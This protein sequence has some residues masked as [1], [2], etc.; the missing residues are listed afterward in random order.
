MDPA[1]GVLLPT[2]F[3]NRF[4]L[5]FRAPVL[6]GL[7]WILWGFDVY[8]FHRFNIP[9]VELLG[10]DASTTLSPWKIVVSGLVYITLIAFVVL[11]F[12]YEVPFHDVLLF[13]SLLYLTLSFALVTPANVMH[14]AGRE[15]LLHNLAKVMFPASTGVLFV[16]VLL[17]DVLTS[18]SKVLADVEVTGCVLAAHLVTPPASIDPEKRGA[19]GEHSYSPHERECMD[20]WMRPLVTSLPFMLRFRQCWVQY[21]VTGK[22]FPH[23]MNC[24]KYL[25]SLPVIWISAWTQSEGHFSRELRMAWIF[26]VSFNSFFS[27]LW[28][29]VMDW[30]LCRQGSRLFLLREHLVFSVWSWASSSSSSPGSST[31]V[32]GGAS[33]DVPG[34]SLSAIAMMPLAAGGG[35]TNAP[36]VMGAALSTTTPRGKMA[37]LPRSAM[38]LT[39]PPK[40]AVPLTPEQG[41]PGADGATGDEET[42]RLLL[43]QRRNSMS[44]TRE[45]SSLVGLGPGGG[46][47]GAGSSANTASSFANSTITILLTSGT[48]YYVAMVFNFV[49]R[50]LWSFKL[51]VHFQLSQ[52]G[53]TFFLEICEVLRRAVWIAFRVEWEAVD[54]GYMANAPPPVGALAGGSVGGG[55]GLG[56]DGGG[57]G[58]GGGVGGGGGGG[59]G[60]GG[61]V[62]SSVGVASAATAPSV[63]AAVARDLGSLVVDVDSHGKKSPRA[64][65]MVAAVPSGAVMM[66]TSAAAARSDGVPISRPSAAPR[67]LDWSNVAGAGAGVGGPASAAA[68]L[69]SSGGGST[70]GVGGGKDAAVVVQRA[71]RESDRG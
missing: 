17:G 40:F 25:S 47:G 51:S 4:P 44:K 16:E 48:I 27:F 7:V 39:N 19:V 2:H 20:S 65:S 10:F 66:H 52:E 46:G 64:S 45:A 14:R 70:G 30:G 63:V 26:A 6:L 49:L 33:E 23:L 31:G 58:G 8:V 36:A 57:G 60:G 55:R 15:R 28:D 68:L 38:V 50:I 24:A 43:Q 71:R 67:V 29:V 32:G 11:G 61:G 54:R 53:L 41:E 62:G 12:V 5:Y 21:R 56:L 9:Y 59:A 13:P 69:S 37:G 42:E 3:A 22:A 35:S 34:A 1:T 18:I